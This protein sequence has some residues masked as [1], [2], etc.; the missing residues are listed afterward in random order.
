MSKK[1]QRLVYPVL[2]LGGLAFGFFLIYPYLFSQKYIEHKT[3]A[4]FQ[5]SLDDKQLAE[6]KAIVRQPFAYLDRGKQSYAFISQDRR[7][8]LKFFDNRCWKSKPGRCQ[9]KLLRLLS[10]YRLAYGKDRDHSGLVFVQLDPNANLDVKANV[11]DRFGFRHE[12]DLSKVPFVL[13]HKAVPLRVVLTELLQQGD[14]AEAKQRLRQI[15]DMY[16]EEYQRGIYD[17]DHNF[18]YNT[19]FIEDKPVRIDV[20]R[21]RFDERYKDKQVYVEDLEKIALDRVG[22][23]MQRHF[24]AYRNEILIDMQ[25]KVKE[26]AG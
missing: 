6:I 5:A 9:R 25:A 1:I 3:N 17:R 13:Q 7:Y 15:I 4:S 23:W 2:L 16:V 19:G 22:G 10:G 21:L 24:P 20:G 12:V 26:V 8:V 18:M 14:V 11:M